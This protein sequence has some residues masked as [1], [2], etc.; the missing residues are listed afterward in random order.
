[1]LP[2]R[3]HA[4]AAPATLARHSPSPRDLAARYRTAGRRVVLYAGTFEPY[5]GLELLVDAAPTVVRATP[6][7]LF[8]CLGGYEAQVAE[9]R[10]QARDN[11]VK[12]HFLFPG[13]VPAETVDAHFALADILVSPRVSG[14]NTPLKIYSYLRSGVPILATSIRAHTQ[15]LNSEVALLVEPRP[16]AIAAGILTLL[17]NG[18]LGQRLTRNALKLAQEHF[19]IEAYYAKVAQLYAF[20]EARKRPRVV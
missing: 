6:D 2:D 16:N 3:E 12:D 19:S 7:T 13:V 9:R 11:G 8:L 5:Q 15:V 10:R 4:I 1:M 20:L 17:E 14:T 18:D